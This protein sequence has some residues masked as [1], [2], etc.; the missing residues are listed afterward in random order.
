LKRNRAKSKAIEKT[1]AN[2]PDLGLVNK[3]SKAARK[4]KEPKTDGK[5]SCIDAAAKVLADKKEPMTTK[6]MIVSY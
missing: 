3:E 5:L 1:L 6:E 2:D 4:P